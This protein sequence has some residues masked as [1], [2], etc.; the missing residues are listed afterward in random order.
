MW[1]ARLFKRKIEETTCTKSSFTQVTKIVQFQIIILFASNQLKH[2]YFKYNFWSSYCSF[3]IV[4][5][6]FLSCVSSRKKFKFETLPD[7]EIC[8]FLLVMLIYL[9]RV[10]RRTSI[11]WQDK[12]WAEFST[13]E[14]VSCMTCTYHAI[15]CTTAWHIV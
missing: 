4:L 15:P 9:S 5:R 6:L 3:L 2:W 13:L 14:E 11:S 10:F 12:T 7:F 1:V 8:L